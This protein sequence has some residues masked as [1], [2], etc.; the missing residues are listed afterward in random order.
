MAKNSK[1]NKDGARRPAANGR[2]A[3]EA[4]ENAMREIGKRESEASLPVPAKKSRGAASGKTSGKTAEKAPGKSG[5][6][7]EK[8]NSGTEAVPESSK[9][10][11]QFIP[12][13]IG[14]IAVFLTACFILGKPDGAMGIVGSTLRNLFCGVFGWPAFFIP[15][16]LVNLAVYWRKYVDLQIVGW[17]VSLS[18]LTVMSIS[19]L[20]HSFMISSTVAGQKYPL[21]DWSKTIF[22]TG[23]AV[24]N[25]ANGKALSGGGF[26][27]GLA[28]GFIRSICGSVGAPIIIIALITVCVMFYFSV[29]PSYVATSI[30]YA[31]FKA[32]EKRAKR[33]E[34]VDHAA[35]VMRAEADRIR[36]AE[37]KKAEERQQK[38]EEERKRAEERRR[39][40]D[41]DRRRAEEDRRKAEE[42]AARAVETLRGTDRGMTGELSPVELGPGAGRVPEPGDTKPS[43][44]GAVSSSMPQDAKAPASPE[45]QTSAGRG[46]KKPLPQDPDEGSSSV[47]ILDEV[48]RGSRTSTSDAGITARDV[49]AALNGGKLP[50]GGTAAEPR[51]AAGPRAATP[52]KTAP[53]PPADASLPVMEEVKATDIAN[54]VPEDDS[55][56]SDTDAAK[57]RAEKLS[58]YFFPPVDL[59]HEVTSPSQEDVLSELK[60]NAQKIM[61]K[62]AAFNARIR[63]ID[64]SRGPTITRY[65]LYPEANTRVSTISAL[66]K[67]I[68]LELGTEIRME[69]PIPGKNAIGI[70]V[71]NRVSATVFIRELIESEKFKSM[72]SKLS[73]CLGKDVGGNMV[74]VDIGKMPH[75]LIAGTTGSGKSV[76]IN[77]L[78]LSILYKARPEEVQFIM[79]DP[80]KIEMGMYN[81]MPHMKVPVVTDMKR[82]AGTLNAAVNEMEHRYNIFSDVGAKG[83]DDYNRMMAE[84]DPDFIPLP[85]LVIII[86][87]L[88]D[89]MM[90]SPGEVEN[91]IIRLA[92]LARAAGIHLIVGT[93]RPSANVITGLIK[94]NIPSRIA[95]SV[96]SN[97]ESRIIID[98]PGAETLIGRGDMLFVPV[99]S[100]KRPAR[101]QGAFV[102]A[103]EVRSV[104]NFIKQNSAEVE[105]DEEFIESIDRETDRLTADDKRGQE[106]SDPAEFSQEADKLFN[107]ALHL[108]VDNGT[109]ATSLLQRKLSIGFGRAAKIIDRM[110]ALGFVSGANGT[111]PRNVL[112]DKQKL[113]ELEMDNDPTVQ[114]R[115]E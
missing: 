18:V 95:F 80:K 21:S 38:A 65:E 87:E 3:A 31:I 29:T 53:Q 79:I 34:E 100:Q 83:L 63:K 10:I 32:R 35:E 108:A 9:L 112:I 54:G 51:P 58:V 96:V 23:G 25:Y 103:E 110:E 77:T 62:L 43:D 11:H 81:G 109:V 24:S 1:N 115:F 26:L 107:Q 106:D 66:S 20:V 67:D 27:G 94:A 6:N 89:L 50:G 40:S 105:Y 57:R 5:K 91:S 8:K 70:E 39:R 101:I 97:V 92:Q 52:S 111:K 44:A 64:Y 47:N 4:A 60:D 56:A 36:D 71:P 76:C 78:I 45:P 15:L 114:G 73:A 84:N 90:T 37:K 59:L 72:T 48:L 16:L 55:P 30:R 82:A 69:A 12:Y 28:G 49:A 75:L 99:G 19:A 2:S 22:G 14:V 74:F 33:R 41:E 46:R 88:A 104:T 13:L 102:D 85:R 98:M 7:A 113:M 17:K 61:N 93:Q 42:D 68:A 86:D